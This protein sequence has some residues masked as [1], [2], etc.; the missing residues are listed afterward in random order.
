MRTPP[1]P[2][3]PNR[4]ACFRTTVHG[5]VFCERA[6]QIGR[7]KAGDE[8]LL[9]P[10]PPTDDEPG[11]WVHTRDGDVVG[12]LPPEIEFW[13]SPWL[14]RGGHAIAHAVKVHGEDVPS[15]RRLLLEVVCG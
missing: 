3:P 9:I 5:T 7:L 4:P 6:S 12:H 14:L 8:V 10:G 15:W 1:L 11:V 13:L 2:V